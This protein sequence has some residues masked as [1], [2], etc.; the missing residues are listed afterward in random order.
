M[1]FFKLS[2]INNWKIPF[3][4]CSGLERQTACGSVP[5]ERFM[6]LSR[7]R[8]R[9]KAMGGLVQVLSG[10]GDLTLAV[11]GKFLELWMIQVYTGLI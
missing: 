5:S 9:Y 3:S 10:L 8:F 4:L 7:Y 6:C 2:K 11:A 1:A